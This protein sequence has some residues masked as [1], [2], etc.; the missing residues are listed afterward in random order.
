[1]AENEDALDR[2]AAW[3]E[4]WFTTLF[5]A[6]KENVF[7]TLLILAIGII[8]WQQTIINTKNEQIIAEKEASKA[9]MIKEV[10]STVSRQLAPVIANNDSATKRLDTSLTRVEKTINKLESKNK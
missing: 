3:L 2:K 7:A 9:E 1:M 5:A 8:F 4:R 10:R 6:I